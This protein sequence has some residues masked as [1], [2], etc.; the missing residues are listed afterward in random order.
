MILIFRHRFP[1]YGDT[2][3]K[4]AGTVATLSTVLSFNDLMFGTR[5]YLIHFNTHRGQ[6][7]EGRSRYLVNLFQVL[8]QLPLWHCCTP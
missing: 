8:R 2:C 4:I 7:Y 5:V 6:R 1:V 3:G